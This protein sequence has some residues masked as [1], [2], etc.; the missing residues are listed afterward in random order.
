VRGSHTGTRA[1]GYGYRDTNGDADSDRHSEADQ[2]TGS[3]DAECHGDSGSGN[4]EAYAGITSLP[5]S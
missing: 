2:Y 5:R 1:S 4:A 3:A